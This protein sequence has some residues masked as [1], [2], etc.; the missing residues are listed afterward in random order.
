MKKAPV[1]P[2]PFFFRRASNSKRS[3]PSGRRHSGK[4]SWWRKAEIKALPLEKTHRVI[5]VNPSGD[6]EWYFSELF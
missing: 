5:A 1:D 6:N 2:G 4:S 3:A